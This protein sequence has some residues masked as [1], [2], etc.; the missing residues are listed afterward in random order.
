MA[1]LPWEDSLLERKGQSDLKDLIKTMVAFANSVAPDHTALILIGEMDDGTIQGVDNPDA[2]QKKL[3]VAAGKIYPPILW[4]SRVYEKE[5]KHCVRVEIEPSGDTPHFG[6][7]AWIRQGS[8]TEIASDAMFQKLIE[9]R[10]SKVRELTKWIGKE[11]SVIPDLGRTEK[12]EAE[13]GATYLH[14]R[15][16][17]EETA[18]LISVNQF[19][20]TFEICSDEASARISE[21]LAKLTL[22]W[23]DV[24]NRIAVLVTV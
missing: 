16:F 1:E 12:I 2:I 7:P 11:V 21:P 6:G 24:N 13:L 8:I 15:W 10:L 17:M 5:G 3:R 14:P 9:V 22:S 19:W 20:T 18:T 23:D 4:R